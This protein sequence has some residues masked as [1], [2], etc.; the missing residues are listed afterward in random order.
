MKAVRAVLLLV[1]MAVSGCGAGN[2]SPPQGTVQ[3]AAP[4]DTSPAPS[5]TT[6]TTDGAEPSVTPYSPVV[7][8]PTGIL[9]P[10]SVARVTA[11]GLRVRGGKPGSPDHSDVI[12]SLAAGDLV[13]IG[14]SPLSYV[15]PDLAPDGRGW[16]EVHVGGAE[17]DSYMDGGING[18]VAEG[19]HGLEWLTAETLMCRGTDTLEG[20]LL[21]PDQ[22]GETHEWATAWDQL[23]CYGGNQLELEGVIETPCYEGSED[24]HLYEPVFL[25]NPDGACVGRHLVVDAIDAEGNHDSRALQLR[26]PPAFGTWPERGS[27]VRVRGH[28]DDPLSSTCT[29]KFPPDADFVAIFDPEFV[30]LACRER[31]VVDDL[32]VIGQRELAPLPWETP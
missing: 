19:E 6:G 7:L 32:S 17:I 18:W 31:F 3:S 30:V 27:L 13:L 16:Y 14:S 24:P 10:D 23:A 8:T 20:V 12:Y 26:F 2:L 4:S 15:P 25:A 28:F 9:A 5:A 11:S 1:A 22:A 29:V 21:P